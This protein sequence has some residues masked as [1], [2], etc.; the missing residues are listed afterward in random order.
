MPTRTWRTKP[1]TTYSWRV[2]PT[3]VFSAREA[4]VRWKDYLVWKFTDGLF[5]NITD[6]DWNK[7]VIYDSTWFEKINY[8]DRDDRT[9]PTTT[10]TARDPI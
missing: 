3:T 7:I 4:L 2:K 6:E 1:S 8:N 9:K 10:R 5:Y